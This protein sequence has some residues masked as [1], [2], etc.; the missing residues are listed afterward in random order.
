MKG[1]APGLALKKGDKTTRNGLSKPSVVAKAVKNCL[2]KPQT[3]VQRPYLLLL[4]KNTYY[5]Y[6]A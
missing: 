2:E 4:P 3:D 5:Y 6:Y 1:C